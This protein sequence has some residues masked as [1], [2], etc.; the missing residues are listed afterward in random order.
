VVS[1]T[2]GKSASGSGG[3]GANVSISGAGLLLSGVRSFGG[4]GLGGATTAA[5]PAA[6]R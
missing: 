6:S 1:A 3:N 2:G 4:N 5:M